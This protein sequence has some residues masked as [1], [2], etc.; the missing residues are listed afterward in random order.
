MSHSSDRLVDRRSCAASMAS[1]RLV[2]VRRSCHAVILW[3]RDERLGRGAIPSQ[4]HRGRGHGGSQGRGPLRH[5]TSKCGRRSRERVD[6]QALIATGNTRSS[7]ASPDASPTQFGPAVS[8][9]GVAMTR[10]NWSLHRAPGANLDVD[11]ARAGREQ[12]CDLS[13]AGRTH[14]PL[15]AWQNGDTGSGYG[16]R[17]RCA[18]AQRDPYHGR[19]WVRHNHSIAACGQRRA[20][21]GSACGDCDDARGLKWWV[22]AAHGPRS[23]CL[24]N[25]ASG[26]RCR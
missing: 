4:R 8:T 7:H 19:G 20:R 14:D 9:G 2:R 1:A 15:R 16:R 17:R 11:G 6:R 22:L 12:D 18:A 23:G 3:V 26:R 10:P 5:A 25:V 21:A 24:R 13:C